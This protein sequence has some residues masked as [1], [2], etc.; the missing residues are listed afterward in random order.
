[1]KTPINTIQHGEFQSLQWLIP[2]NSVDLVVT[3]PPYAMQRSAHY[4]GINEILYPEWTTGWMRILKRI[5]KPSGSVMINIRPHVKAGAI[6]DYMLRTRLAVRADGW[7]ELDEWIWLK[8]D[9]VPLGHN[10][11]PRRSWESL[12]WFARCKNPYCDAKATGTWS[13]RIGVSSRKGLAAGYVHGVSAKASSGLARSADVLVALTNHNDRSPFNTH[14]AQFPVTLVEQIIQ[15]LCPIGGMV[16]DPFI[17][18]GTTAIAAMRHRRQFVGFEREQ[19]YVNIANRR[20]REHQR[21]P[22]SNDFFLWLNTVN[23][24]GSDPEPMLADILADAAEIT[25]AK[26]R[27]KSGRKPNALPI[28][29]P[30][31][32]M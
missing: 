8:P 13:N 20:I 12:H 14:P 19:E 25:T 27:N 7:R 1:M 22:A 21:N 32:M 16:L 31:R 5:L 23:N 28:N 11:R 18:S 10:R 29:D 26:V 4:G 15:A 24:V 2:D 6:S 3:S 30:N 17:G 9:S